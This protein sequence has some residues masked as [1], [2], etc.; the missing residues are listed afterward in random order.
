MLKNLIQIVLS[1]ICLIISL[2]ASGFYV[3][4]N[5]GHI[6]FR[7][8]MLEDWIIW[9]IV[10]LFGMLGFWLIFNMIKKR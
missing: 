6:M 9:G 10:L 3:V 8:H 1:I 7:P 4:G 2:S 5:H